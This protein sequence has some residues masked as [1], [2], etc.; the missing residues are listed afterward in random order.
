MNPAIALSGGPVSTAQG[1]Y[2]PTGFVSR[3]LGFV[4][5]LLG[6]Q[7]ALLVALL[8]GLVEL[9]A[10][11]AI[12][13]ASGLVLVAWLVWRR[14]AVPVD[15]LC[16]AALQIVVWSAVAGPFGTFV[17]AA[18]AFR[19][20]SIRAPVMTG[21]DGESLRA[22]TSEIKRATHVHLAMLDHRIRLEGA[23][24]SRPLMDVIAEGSQLEKLEALAVV[25]RKY[26]AGLA[27]VLKRALRDRDTSIRVL[28]ATIT[29]KLNGTF[30]RKIGDCQ[31]AVAAMPD[32]AQ[33]WRNI[34]EA[35]LAYANS[36]LLE[37]SRA[38]IEIESAI[39]D[40]A[41]AAELDPIDR[42]TGDRLD[43]ARHQLVAWRM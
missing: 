1:G 7:I 38:R 11:L 25:Y 36:G 23:H 19:P 6:W 42:S 8:C 4:V 20:A 37:A 18:L 39:G 12:H 24:H 35:R 16:A 26:D 43:G 14:S 17:A 22:D 30:S 41:R 40:L 15:S 5:A 21:G 27:A 10:Y 13:L 28:A 2:F 33:S 3:L 9:G 34:A 31:T 32:L 29:A